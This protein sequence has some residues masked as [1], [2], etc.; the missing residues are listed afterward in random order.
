MEVTLISNRWPCGNI[1]VVVVFAF[2]FIF[3]EGSAYVLLIREVS[4]DVLLN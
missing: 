3:G 1:K 4:I 2:Y